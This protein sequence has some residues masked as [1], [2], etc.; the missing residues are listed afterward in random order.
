MAGVDS[1][2]GAGG[3][4]GTGGA[5]ECGAAEAGGS[6][7]GVRKAG[8]YAR[9]GAASLLGGALIGASG[10]L[11]APAVV[12][13]A[14]LMGSS[15]G[16]GTAAA[17]IGVS[18]GTLGAG[19]V[20]FKYARRQAD[21]DEFFFDLIDKSPGLPL[22]VGVGGWLDGA[23][24][25]HF[26]IWDKAFCGV[27]QSDGGET[28]AL[29]WESSLL[30]EV[31]AAIYTFVRDQ[32]VQQA[33]GVA[34]TAVLGAAFVSMT[35]P[36]AMLQ[37]CDMIDNAWALA[38]KRADAAGRQLAHALLQRRQHGDRP[39]TLVGFGLGARV[40]LSSLVELA[41]MGPQ[42]LGIVETAA[43]LGT[44]FG[45]DPDTWTQA[46][47]VCSFRLINGYTSKD[48]IL[49]LVY[50]SSSLQ[51]KVAGLVPVELPPQA[52][53]SPALVLENVCLD[54]IVH[55][56]YEYRDKLA[57]IMDFVGLSSGRT[58]PQP[59]DVAGSM[60]QG[61]AQSRGQSPVRG[62]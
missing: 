14:G 22:T 26:R 47:S 51:R 3:G 1:A 6:K 27:G 36:L 4:E 29:R 33:I 59:P 7:E 23:V 46:A 52:S 11:G 60:P 62:I 25:S 17:A 20:G 41:S 50:R 9:L 54:G 53:L 45:L 44:P 2:H 57:V 48:W 28:V 32:T 39:V 55:G 43:L 38:S 10:T 21:L 49:A 40:I 42:G 13:A 56:H 24:D 15:V 37:A 30:R 61:H 58:L 12:A 18:F 19:L 31:G 16:S 5:A 8:R 34:G 35:L